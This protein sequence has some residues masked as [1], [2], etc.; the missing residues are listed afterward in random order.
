MMIEQIW[1]KDMTVE[2]KEQGSRILYDEPSRDLDPNNQDTW[3]PRFVVLSSLWAFKVIKEETI[4]SALRY[5]IWPT[6]FSSKAGFQSSWR[7][8]GQAPVVRDDEGTPRYP[9]VFGNVQL[10]GQ[11]GERRGLHTTLTALNL[12]PHNKHSYTFGDSVAGPES[13][14]SAAPQTTKPTHSTVAGPASA[15]SAAPQ[16]TKHTLSTAPAANSTFSAALQTRKPTLSAASLAAAG[17]TTTPTLSA[18]RNSP[19]SLTKQQL[20]APLLKPSSAQIQ[21]PIEQ[22]RQ[23]QRPNPR[24]PIEVFPTSPPQLDPGETIIFDMAGKPFTLND[25]NIRV[26]YKPVPLQKRKREDA[27]SGNSSARKK[28]TPALKPSIEKPIKVEEDHTIRILTE[29]SESSSDSDEDEYDRLKEELAG[30][31]K[32]YIDGLSSSLA[33]EE[34]LAKADGKVVLMSG[35]LRQAYNAINHLNE[36]L[37]SSTKMVKSLLKGDLPAT[38]RKEAES[39]LATRKATGFSINAFNKALSTMVRCFPGTTRIVS[40]SEADLQAWM[41]DRTVPLGRKAVEIG[42]KSIN[43]KGEVIGDEE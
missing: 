26:P 6:T 16:T 5:A 36:G 37:N 13:P 9:V 11:E 4:P 8:N 14:F 42:D 17:Q 38:S 2:D 7:N 25:Q 20:T 22:Q 21:L 43:A 28:R 29:S 27:L 18:L 23:T 19:Y 40:R 33:L 34:M 35:V 3:P 41:E 30:V 12:R 32:D 31:K 15:P 1:F 24:T 39:I 10:H